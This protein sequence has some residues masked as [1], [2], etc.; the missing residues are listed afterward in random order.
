MAKDM[1]VLMFDDGHE[2]GP[3]AVFNKKPSNKQLADL[4]VA[5]G[6]ETVEEVV[7]SFAEGMFWEK[8]PFFKV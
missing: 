5:E 4:E 7:E 1:Y 3:L 8:V 6:M 2:F